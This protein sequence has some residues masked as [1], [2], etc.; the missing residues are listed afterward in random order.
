MKRF[1]FL[2]VALSS[3]LFAK[4]K[5]DLL[6]VGF[7]AG[8]SNIWMQVLKSWE[9]APDVQVLTMAAASKVVK[10]ASLDHVIEIESLG[11]SCSAN[12]RLQEFSPEELQKLDVLSAPVLVTG[13]YS[14][15]ERQIAEAFAKKGSKVI[16]VWDNF[17]TY[18]KL[19]ADLVANV[20]QII[21]VA[22]AILV[23][24]SEI[25]ADLNARFK[26]DKAVAMGQPTL[27]MWEEKIAEVDRKKALAKTSFSS[28]LPILTYIS[29]YEEK[30]NGYNDSFV[31]FAR[32]L[33]ALDKPAQVIVQLHPR[34]DGSFEKRILESFSSQN[35]DFPAFFISDGKQLSTIEA[36]A[37][38]DLGICHRSTVAI[39]ALFAGKRFMHVDLPDTSFSHF[40]IEKGLI[41]Q[42]LSVDT[43][44]KYIAEHLRDPVQTAALYEEAGIPQSATQIFQ[45]FLRDLAERETKAEKQ[46]SSLIE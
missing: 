36:V 12:Q 20:A 31:L 17:S 10:D 46:E 5:S 4:E 40:A 23:P 41:P 44:A 27:Q 15:P 11:L 33:N 13:M 2:F 3:T 24:S 19:P 42:C 18:D 6:F 37:L 32:S 29:G 8:E 30:G 25:A 35:P 7:D 34:S 1:I 39:Q 38:S 16:G 43:A 21:A 28:Q 9:D 26:T 22:E 14:A 45:G